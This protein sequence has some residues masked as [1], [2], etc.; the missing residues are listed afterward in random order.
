VPPVTFCVPWRPI[1]GIGPYQG[2]VASPMMNRWSEC[3][4]MCQTGAD[5][6]NTT[7]SMTMMSSCRKY[8]GYAR[9]WMEV[10]YPTVAYINSYVI[11]FLDPFSLPKQ[12]PQPP[13]VTSTMVEN[14]EYMTSG[15]KQ[16]DPL[17]IGPLGG[18]L[19]RE[20]STP[21]QT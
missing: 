9:L 1:G 17:N 16:I 15:R 13:F 4:W 2:T 18:P 19:G 10:P 21:W 12:H 11:P 7:T 8:H 3:P 6:V 5:G 20:N 14:I